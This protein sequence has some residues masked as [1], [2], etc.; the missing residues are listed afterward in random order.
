MWVLDDGGDDE[1]KAWVEGEAVEM[2]GAGRVRY[3]RRTKPKGVPH[4]FKAG[5]INHGLQHASGEFIAILDADMIPSK[6]FL[7]SLLPHF[8]A[9]DIA[10]VQC[11]QS[12]YNIVK[13]DP[14]NDASQDFYDVLLPHR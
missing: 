12:F 9:P 4:H 11:P 6:Y 5:N 10:F 7:S 2:Y 13:G 14:L 8:T 3:L 1:L